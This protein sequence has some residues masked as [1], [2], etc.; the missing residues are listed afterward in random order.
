MAVEDHFDLVIIG[1]GPA[2]LTAAL[3]ASKGP[4]PL[5]ICLIDRKKEPGM[6]VRCGEAI[7][8]TG[9]E[10]SVH[11]DPAWIKSPIRTVKLF[12]PSGVAV[13]FPGFPL[14]YIIDRQR[15]ESDLT[16]QVR[17]AGVKFVPGSTIV[18]VA[19]GLNRTYECVSDSGRRYKASCLILA[20]GIES[21]AARSLG[22]N[23][24][25][26]CRD[27]ITC[28][29]ARVEHPAVE[30]DACHFFLGNSIAPGGYAWV[31]SRGEFQAN[32]G[33]GISGAQCRAGKPLS[34][35][36]NFIES[37]YPGARVSCVHSGGVPIARG[38]SP[39]VKD[40]VML[41][42]DAARQVHCVTGAGLAYAL[43]SGKMAGLAARAAFSGVD[44][45]CRQLRRYA[46]QWSTHYGKQQH[47]SYSLKR[48]I[49]GFPDAF[50]NEIADSLASVS[51]QNLNPSRILIRAFAKH[52][53]LAIKAARL[54]R[55]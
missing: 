23:T 6:P 36:S 13:A 26:R 3:H 55:L 34:L 35:L 10:S 44:F 11:V 29:F 40:G 28:A 25:L 8:L 54:F 33:I 51:S 42:G 18:S 32:V 9:F 52:P 15:M 1:A 22:W 30:S 12:A 48:A 4:C 2:G 50:L 17:Q 37:H 21:G 19:S 24:V 45:D 49:D 14:S 46:K 43:Y 31:F 41:A 38:L 5:R 16:A 27:I 47:R 53:L 39:L 20:D 7:S